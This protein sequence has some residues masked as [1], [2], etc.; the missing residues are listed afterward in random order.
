[1]HEA[2][3]AATRFTYGGALASI[4]GLSLPCGFSANGLPI[5]MMLEAAWWNEP[6]LLR[7]GCAYQAAT[8]WHL[9]R[10]PLLTGSA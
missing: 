4:P 8:D 10:P 1:L 3:G 5:G 6:L 9:K 2:T 7:A